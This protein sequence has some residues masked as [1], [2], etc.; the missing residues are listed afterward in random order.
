MGGEW[1]SGVAD[2]ETIRR[3][4]VVSSPVF[5]S[6][7]TRQGNFLASIV[8]GALFP[9]LGW[10]GMFMSRAPALLVLY[11]ADAC[12]IAKLG[13][14]TAARSGTLAIVRSHWR[15]AFMPCS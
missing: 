8:Y 5:S 14:A 15:L 6:Q 9:H 12:R 7:A 11:I 3:M 1:A 13:R 10:R 4:R 2:E